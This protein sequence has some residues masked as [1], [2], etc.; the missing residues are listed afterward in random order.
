[1]SEGWSLGSVLSP[2]PSCADSVAGEGG[3]GLEELLGGWMWPR[4]VDGL[5]VAEPFGKHGAGAGDQSL[6]ESWVHGLG[7]AECSECTA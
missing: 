7:G 6:G 1:M 2:W 5:A 4:V 3:W